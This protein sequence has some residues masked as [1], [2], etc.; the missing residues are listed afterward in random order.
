MANSAGAAP[1]RIVAAEA[2]GELRQLACL[3]GLAVSTHAT[4]ESGSSGALLRRRPL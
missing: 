4:T 2:H 3:G 1:V